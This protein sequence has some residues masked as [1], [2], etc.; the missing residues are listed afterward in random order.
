MDAQ[1]IMTQYWRYIAE[2]NAEK[3]SSFF[4]EGAYICWHCSNEQFTVPEFIRANCEYPGE[5]NAEI[6]RI[7]QVGNII[8]TVAHVWSGDISFHAV[9][10]FKM[11]QGKVIALD[12]YWGDDGEAP[13]WRLEKHIGTKINQLNI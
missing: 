8:I 11:V 3:L 4:H 12:E 7:E 13:Q 5:W 6:E 9:S 1:K 10:F 2:Q